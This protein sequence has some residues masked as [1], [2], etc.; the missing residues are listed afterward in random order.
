MVHERQL[1][2]RVELACFLNPKLLCCTW[3]RENAGT[4]VI[5][6]D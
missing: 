3:K 2:E 5:D 1:E 4:T 6:P